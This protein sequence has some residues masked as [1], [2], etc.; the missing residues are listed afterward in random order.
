MQ[1]EQR[2]TIWTVK[3]KRVYDH[4]TSH[5]LMFRQV[6]TRLLKRVVPRCTKSHYTCV[7]FSILPSTML[8]ALVVLV[9]LATMAEAEL[10][11][12]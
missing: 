11:C 10:R 9:D 12:V 3:S 1:D 8:L 5:L 7:E 2:P 6:L 4:A